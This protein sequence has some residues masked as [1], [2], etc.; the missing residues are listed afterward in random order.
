VFP[1]ALTAPVTGITAGASTLDVLSPKLKT[2]YSE[3]A[4]IA[5]ERQLAKDMVLTVSGIFSRGVDLYGTQDANAPALGAPFTYKIDDANGNQVGTYTTQVY[6]NPRPNPA[7][8][9]IYTLTN[10]VSSWY[11]GLAVTFDK[12]FS[13]GFQ[14]LVSYTWSHAIDDGQ[15]SSTNAVF[16][17]S[18]AAWIYN[19]QYAFDKGASYNDQR[20]RLVVSWIW[21]PE[22]TRSTSAFAKYVVNNWQLSNIT[23][24]TTGHPSGSE[25][26]HLNDTPVTGCSTAPMPSMDSTELPCSVP[27]CEYAL[28]AGVPAGELPP[29]QEHPLPRENMKLG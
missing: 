25:T 4:T 23:S 29:D 28:Y 19:G 7:F 20:Q 18:D 21:A 15:G 26:I 10:G 2:P 17:F 24:I 22:F 3:Q 11:D 6:L 9:A 16:G 14:G 12:K 13:H 8:G 27:G 5:V 1:N